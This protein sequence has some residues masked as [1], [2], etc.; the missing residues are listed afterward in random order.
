MLSV[1]YVDIVRF[2]K[3]NVRVFSMLVRSFVLTLIFVSFV[4]VASV[5]AQTATKSDSNNDNNTS[6]QGEALDDT[7]LA[8]AQSKALTDQ[9]STIMSGL[10]ADELNHFMVLFTNYNMYSIVVNVRRDV[11]NAV[12][13][14]GE[15]N[16][17]MK[18]ELDSRFESWDEA[19]SEGMEQSWNNIE[20]LG[21]AQ[22]YISQ[23]DLKMV[24]GLV[25]KT[26]GT[27]SSQ[28]KKIPLTT[29]EACEFMLSKM[30]ETQNSMM[31]LLRA[32]NQSYPAILK[33]N[34]K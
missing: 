8:K 20:S 12:K 21:L 16:K 23:N 13:L 15:N 17:E 14:C 33:K 5:S 29:P 7:A 1:Y 10:A 28:F 31:L 27:D 25:E 32:T 9:V 30:D 26:R 19:V 4:S 24:Y 34:Q 11:Q 6:P 2:E 18:S 3:L 22:S